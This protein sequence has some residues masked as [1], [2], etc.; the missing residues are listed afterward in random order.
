MYVVPSDSPHSCRSM[1]L[2]II[3]IQSEPESVA[4]QKREKAEEPTPA[5]QCKYRVAIPDVAANT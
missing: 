2:N 5:V 3:Q 1:R 4:E